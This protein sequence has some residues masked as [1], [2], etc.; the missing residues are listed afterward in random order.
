M[1]LFAAILL[2]Q[3]VV[4]A[5]D[6]SETHPPAVAAKQWGAFIFLP[7]FPDTA[8]FL[9]MFELRPFFR[10]HFA[11]SPR[12]KLKAEIAKLGNLTSDL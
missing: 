12:H 4:Y 8:F 7:H 1:R 3:S 9:K 2:A 11:R 6:H 10:I 5:P